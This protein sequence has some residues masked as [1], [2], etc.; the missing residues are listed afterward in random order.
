MRYELAVVQARNAINYFSLKI[1]EVIN[2]SMEFLSIILSIDE[3]YYA[4]NTARL[5]TNNKSHLFCQ[6][7]LQPTKYKGF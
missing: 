2:K 6:L 4:N 7:H 3:N 1:D 5:R